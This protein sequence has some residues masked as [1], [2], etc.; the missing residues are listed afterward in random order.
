MAKKNFIKV[1]TPVG[2]AQYAWLARPDTGH[3]FSD[4]KY[5]VTLLMNPEDAGVKEAIGKINE[6]V[7]DAAIAEWGKLPKV[8]R[9][10]IKN[11][12]DIADEKEGKEDL[13][14]L[15][16]LTTK[17]KFQPGMVDAKRNELPED[18]FVSSGDTSRVSAVLIPYT[19]GGMKGVALQ[20]RNVQLLEQRTANGDGGDEFDDVDGYSTEFAV[21]PLNQD[22]PP[23]GPSDEAEPDDF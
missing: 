7:E 20:L 14:G 22:T 16:M 18:V 3:E 4:G 1:V 8:H 6:A 5:K 2:T 11:G 13:R 23:A 9:S 21:S 12:D 10:P 19:A 15:F 17:S